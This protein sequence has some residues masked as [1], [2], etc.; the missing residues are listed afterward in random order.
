MIIA[1]NTVVSI[2]YTLTNDEG[3]VIDSSEGRAPLV[4]MHGHGNIVVGLERALAGKQVGDNVHVSVP[5]A[6]GYGEHDPARIQAVPRT[7]LPPDMNVQPGMQLMARGPDGGVFPLWVVQVE[8]DGIVVDGNH[9]LAGE[10]LNFVV[11]VRAIRAATAE[12]L[13]HGHV[14]GEGGH[15]H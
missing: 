13:Q 2:D 12:E 14:H 4:Y 11:D 6:E 10:T 8:E 1:Q 3:E 7:A 9:P 15:H 5:P